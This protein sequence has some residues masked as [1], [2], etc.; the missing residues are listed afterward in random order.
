[1]EEGM[2]SVARRKWVMAGSSSQ[3]KEAVVLGEY[4]EFLTKQMMPRNC[5]EDS[6]IVAGDSLGDRPPLLLC[7]G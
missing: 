7:P 2:K 6:D 1:M 3:A 4:Q 5:G